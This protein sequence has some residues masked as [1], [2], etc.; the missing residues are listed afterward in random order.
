MLQSWGVGWQEVEK[1][2][3]NAYIKLQ[4]CEVWPVRAGTEE[5]GERGGI[6]VGII[7]GTFGNRI[8]RSVRLGPR[9]E[10][11]IC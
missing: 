10:I 2:F 3:K 4:I 11:H 1:E 6:F 5:F 8:E 9:I 7:I